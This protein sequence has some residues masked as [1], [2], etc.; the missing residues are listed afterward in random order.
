[1][2]VEQEAPRGVPH[3]PQE[4][5]PVL[6][7]ELGLA[8]QLTQLVV[9]GLAQALQRVWS[10]RWGQARRPMTVVRLAWKASRPAVEL[11]R[12]LS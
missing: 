10:Q 12:R 5:V 2:P 11:G 7:L 9:L 1:M 3:L 6:K 4:L 8:G